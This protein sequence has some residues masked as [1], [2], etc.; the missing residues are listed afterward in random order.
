MDSDLSNPAGISAS[1]RDVRVYSTRRLRSGHG[2][3]NLPTVDDALGFQLPEIRAYHSHVVRVGGRSYLIWSCYI[4]YHPVPP[5]AESG[6]PAY[7]AV[8]LI[9]ILRHYAGLSPV[10][11]LR[12][13]GLRT[14]V[15]PLA[16]DG[17]SRNEVF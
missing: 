10:H 13:A 2:Y 7:Y 5:P 3:R 8:R 4:P 12:S 1:E 17:F 11:I 14:S 16:E 6:L 9:T 15:R